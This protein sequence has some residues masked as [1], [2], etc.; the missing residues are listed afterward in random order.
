MIFWTSLLKEGKRS[1][2]TYR[3]SGGEKGEGKTFFP[4]FLGGKLKFL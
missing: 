3:E 2:K 1:E 4:L